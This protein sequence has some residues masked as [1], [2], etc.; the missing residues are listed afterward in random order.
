MNQHHLLVTELA[1]LRRRDLL[2]DAD[3]HRPA[4]RDRTRNRRGLRRRAD[5]A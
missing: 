5:Q 2:A 1:D 4:R 3:R